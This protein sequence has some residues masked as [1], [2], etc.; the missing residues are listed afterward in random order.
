MSATELINVALT[1]VLFMGIVG[2][3]S[4]QKSRSSTS[5]SRATFLPDEA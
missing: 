1:C 5:D 2:W 4:Y 3:I